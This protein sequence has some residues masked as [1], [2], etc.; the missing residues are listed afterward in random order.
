MTSITTEEIGERS[1]LVKYL[2]SFIYHPFVPLSKKEK[3]RVLGKYREAANRYLPLIEQRTGIDLGE[4]KVEW[5]GN[6]F[7]CEFK[8]HL[9]KAL[10]ETK[11]KVQRGALLILGS[12]LYPIIELIRMYEEDFSSAHYNERTQT[13]C[14]PFGLYSK[15]SI[16]EEVM[17]GSSQAI[18]ETIIHE[19]THHLWNSV[20][21]RIKMSETPD[22]LTEGYAIYGEHNWFADLLPDGR[23]LGNPEDYLKHY[24]EGRKIIEKLV[25]RH[26]E[27]ILLEIPV[28][29]KELELDSAA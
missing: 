21:N 26:G 7:R 8:H 6:S 25:Q 4:V 18:D 15:A 14:V 23:N 16:L 20:P 1:W 2:T 9:D 10:G 13:I 3:E 28:I 24:L 11:N 17:Y 27:G 19:L 22:L 5:I 12:G 29:W